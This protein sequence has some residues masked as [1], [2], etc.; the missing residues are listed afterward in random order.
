MTS[1][2]QPSS[3]RVVIIERITLVGGPAGLIAL[4]GPATNATGGTI[5]ALCAIVVSITAVALWKDWIDRAIRSSIAVCV[6][7][8][9]TVAALLALSST[10][11]N[12]SPH[13]QG[14]PAP[15]PDA[16]LAAAVPSKPYVIRSLVYA[17]RI[18]NTTEKS[19]VV[20]SLRATYMLE[21]TRAISAKE[22]AFVEAFHSHHP[23]AVRIYWPG[24]E[25]EK[26]DPIEQGQYRVE[27]D[28]APRETRTVMTGVDFRLP[29]PFGHRPTPDG[30]D[31]LTQWEDTINYPNEAEDVICDI[32]LIVESSS[33]PVVEAGSLSGKRGV[34]KPE[35]VKPT[36]RAANNRYSVSSRWSMLKPKEVVWLKY[37]IDAAAVG[38]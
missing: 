20:E 6:A 5:A 15:I 27:L 31:P 29:F 21:A 8:V 37:R 1:E 14:A 28:L 9:A 10:Q 2:S 4:L 13:S 33:L 11:G 19:S 16:C 34:S 38:K 26:M 25:P 23:G 7:A 18:E 30:M 24:T 35:M 17:A 12:G 36:Y 32:T 22:P 3:R